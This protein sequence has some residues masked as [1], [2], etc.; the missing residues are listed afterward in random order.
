MEVG[1]SDNQAKQDCPG[2]C[3]GCGGA[4]RDSHSHQMADA[5]IAG[6]YVGWQLAGSAAVS[7]LLPIGLA[8][9]ASA[10]AGEGQN[11][12]CLGAI[13]GLIAGIVIA[14]IVVRI[15]FRK[16]LKTQDENPSD[17]EF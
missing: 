17:K 2:E 1:D 9:V 15:F 5:Q 16:N 7:F 6:G 8:I 12:R 10:L 4:D 14:V 11:R 13:A 3:P